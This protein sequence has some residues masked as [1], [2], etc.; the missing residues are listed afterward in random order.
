VCYYR[1]SIICCTVAHRTPRLLPQKDG[2]PT[3]YAPPNE[4]VRRETADV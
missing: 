2:P 4:A 3:A 1:T